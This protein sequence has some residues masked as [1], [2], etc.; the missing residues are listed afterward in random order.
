MAEICSSL[1][2]GARIPQALQAGNNNADKRRRRRYRLEKKRR[3]KAT[4]GPAFSACL[5]FSETVRLLPLVL[6]LFGESIWRY[7]Q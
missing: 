2:V 4:A 7:G 5:S 3:D 6:A 1:G